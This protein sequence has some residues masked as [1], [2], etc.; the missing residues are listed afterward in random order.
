MDAAGHVFL[1]DFG[2]VV[3]LEEEA[4]E[5]SQQ[6][7]PVDLADDLLRRVSPRVDHVMLVCM[8]SLAVGALSRDSSFDIEDH[9][10]MRALNRGMGVPKQFDMSA[11]RQAVETVQHDDLRNFLYDLLC[12]SGDS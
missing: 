12:S 8:L 5:T 6:W 7:L 4:R 1:G 10:G 3:K 9:G 2:A 11:L